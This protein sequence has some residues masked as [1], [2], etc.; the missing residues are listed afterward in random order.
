M[1]DPV[2]QKKEFSDWIEEAD[3]SELKALK[4]VRKAERSI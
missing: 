1:T 2:K 3:E 4:T